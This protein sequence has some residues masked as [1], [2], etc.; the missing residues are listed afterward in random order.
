MIVT[1]AHL[2]NDHRLVMDIQYFT[3]DSLYYVSFGNQ[4]IKRTDDFLK[5]WKPHE[6]T[7]SAYDRLQ[8]RSPDNPTGTKAYTS[9]SRNLPRRQPQLHPEMGARSAHTKKLTQDAIT[10]KLRRLT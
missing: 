2:V 9:G 5:R 6:H 3:Y 8:R 1:T 7:G 10:Q 4:C